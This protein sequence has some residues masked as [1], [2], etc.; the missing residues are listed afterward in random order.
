MSPSKTQ[1]NG[2]NPGRNEHVSND[3]EFI[4][5]DNGNSSKPNKYNVNRLEYSFNKHCSS[6]YKYDCNHDEYDSYPSDEV[7]S[8]QDH[9]ADNPRNSL[10]PKL[11]LLTVTS[12]STRN[13]KIS[14]TVFSTLAF[15]PEKLNLC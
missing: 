5:Q 6:Y 2:Y 11:Q 3:N 9:A 1:S 12:A 7:Y 10:F 13:L 15:I 4:L 14:Y 8:N